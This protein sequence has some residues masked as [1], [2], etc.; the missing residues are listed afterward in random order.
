MKKERMIGRA[1]YAGY[2]LIIMQGF[3]MALL[4]VFILNQK[5]MTVWRTY[6]QSN[7]STTV[8]M[9]NV[10]AEKQQ[11]TQ[12]FLLMA[13]NYQ[14]LFISRMDMILDNG[15]S[16]DGYK[17]GIYGNTDGQPVGLSFLDESI[18]T[19]ADLKKLMDSDNPEST[20]GVET[21]SI[22][23]IGAIPDFRFY[24]H[25]VIK[26]LPCLFEDSQ[27]VNGTYTILG[28]KSDAERETF[29]HDLAKASGLSESDL[30]EPGSGNATNNQIMR[31]VLC[32][33]LAAQIFLNIVFFLVV[34]MKNL[35]KQGKLTLLGWSRTAFAKKILGGF[36][37][38]SVAAVPVLTVA[39]G[40]IAGWGK[41]SVTLLACYLVAACANV[42]LVLVELLI[43]ASV[44]MMTKPLDAIRGRIPKKTLYALG[45]AAYLAICAGLVFCGGYVDQPISSISDNARLT[46]RWASV[47]EY[48]LLRDFSVGQD[49]DSFSGNSKELDQDLYNW[50]S[51]IADI[52]GVYL[53]QTD[54]YDEEIL[55]EWQSYHTYS[56]MPSEPVWLFTMS[57]SYLENLGV[58]IENNALVSAKSGARLY[59]IPSGLSDEE[60]KHISD[61]LQER[62]TRSLSEGDIQ[63]IFTQTPS[64]LFVEY[65]PNQQFF[66]WT[67][68]DQN[69]METDAPII[70]VA[71]PQNMNYTETESLKASGFNGY[72]KFADA[73][74]ASICTEA[75]ILSSYHLTDNELV[76]TDVHNYI[77]GLQ[78]ELGI[79][80]M[81]FGL[82]FLMLLLSLVGLLLT[83][84]A[85]FRIVNQEK[86]N[87]KKFM[88][89]SFFQMYGKPMLFLSVL[90]VFEL[91]AMLV[92]GSK[93]GLLLVIMASAIQVLIFVKYM[94][95]NELKNVLAAFKGE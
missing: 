74:T 2:L 13:A 51:S 85:V 30:L 43:S 59:L 77:D 37:I 79:T 86:I 56:S 72:I 73:Q 47:S 38:F 31:D 82:V 78:K 60:Q 14:N 81:W 15:G 6:P 62:D 39:N 34:T 40:L 41:L 46:R 36:L 33:F 8:Y 32:A 63:T 11:D 20:L 10:S 67:T 17:F 75:K 70:Y 68:D 57:P 95:H 84:A 92:M 16:T 94:A 64:F 93:F 88:G 23:S 9:K 87:V 83:L 25:V 90:I 76:F 1:R 28:L 53:I 3:I 54:Y 45:I 18:L 48:Q 27:T 58:E 24:E 42:I 26:K 7:E 35:P 66:T 61:W 49:G 29:L 50:Y 52:P 5:Y 80:L 69:S 55:A 12:E 44:I 19:A 4:A 21:G 22:Y 71:T 65:E 91:A 89:F